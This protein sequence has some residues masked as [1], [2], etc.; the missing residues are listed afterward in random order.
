LAFAQL[1]QQDSPSVGELKR[2]VVD[3]WLAVVDLAK[4]RHLMPEPQNGNLL[5]I[6]DMDAVPCSAA[7]DRHS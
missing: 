1:R 5:S 7:S 2:I 6:C 3:I 4:L